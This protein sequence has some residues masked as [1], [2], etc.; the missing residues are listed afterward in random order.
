MNDP[1]EGSGLQATMALQFVARD[2]TAALDEA[3]LRT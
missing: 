1:S 2:E 3:A